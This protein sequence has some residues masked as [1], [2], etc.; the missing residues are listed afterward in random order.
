MLR[1]SK[2]RIQ[3]QGAFERLYHAVSCKSRPFNRGASLRFPTIQ[4]LQGALLL[5]EVDE[6]LGPHLNRTIRRGC[7]G[8]F[9][10]VWSESLSSNALHTAAF[11]FSIIVTP[12]TPRR[13]FTS[14]SSSSM[15]W[16]Q[17]PR[18]LRPSSIAS[19]FCS[20]GDCFSCAIN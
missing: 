7:I 11:V 18:R 13:F 12:F 9:P 19:F 4:L 20:H 8:N 3:A 6:V 17:R 14:D 2:P 5:F 16:L 10:H 1:N 15:I